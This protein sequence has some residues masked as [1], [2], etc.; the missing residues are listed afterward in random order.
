MVGETAFA[1]G[2]I[3]SNS[4]GKVELRGSAWNARNVGE[5]AVNPKQ[6]CKV[7]KVDGLTLWVRGE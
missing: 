5:E 4:F 6:R 1:V 7:E 2:R 3:Q